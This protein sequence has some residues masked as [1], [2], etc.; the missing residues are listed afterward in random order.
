MGLI[1]YAKL[2]CERIVN[3]DGWI[4]IELR[5]EPMNGLDIRAIRSRFKGS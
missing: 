1:M 3:T 5:T 2:A 4:T